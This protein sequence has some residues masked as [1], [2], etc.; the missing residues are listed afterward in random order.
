MTVEE[1]LVVLQTSGAKMLARKG[2][3]NL[4]KW[5]SGCYSVDKITAGC[6]GSLIFSDDKENVVAFFQDACKKQ[7]KGKYDFN[8]EVYCRG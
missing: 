5:E 3:L 4:L 7:R 2:N 1:R 8:L 6:D